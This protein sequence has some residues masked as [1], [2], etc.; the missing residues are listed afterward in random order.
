MTGDKEGGPSEIGPPGFHAVTR[1]VQM[2]ISHKTAG[3]PPKQGMYDPAYERD[4]CG[5]GFVAQARGVTVRCEQADLLA[6]DWAARAGSDRYDWV[7]GIFIQFASPAERARQ[8]AIMQQLTRP[9]GCILLQGYTPKQLDYRTGGPS[10]VENLYTADMMR[11]A[12]AGWDIEELV[13][14]EEAV[15]EGSGHSGMSAL[16][17]LVARKPLS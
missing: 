10:A 14:Y 5:M 15:E 2:Q 9:G 1:G 11:K 16:L 8:F 6:P 12:F 4:A 13:E 17:G 3:L 7:I